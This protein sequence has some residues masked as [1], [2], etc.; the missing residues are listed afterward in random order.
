MRDNGPITNREIELA[1][2]ELLVSRTDTT[3]RITFVNKA[4]VDVCGYSEA[5][6]VGAPHNLVRH[7]H[8]PEAAF[9]DL[10]AT[11]KAGRPWEGLVKNRAKSGDFYWV[12]ANV[13]PVVEDGRVTG[14]IS[15]RSKPARDQVA[16]AERLYARMREGMLVQSGW[17]TK[18][19]ALRDSVSGRLGAVFALLFLITALVGWLGLDGM[20][21]SNAALRTVYEKR[22]VTAGQLGDVIDRMH[23]TMQQLTLLLVDVR[24]GTGRTVVDGR[25]QRIQGN[26][27]RITEVLDTYLGS[28]L[29]AEEQALARRFAELRGDFVREGLEPALAMVASGDALALERHHGTRLA[30]L[31]EAAHTANRALMTLQV[32]EAS[33][34]YATAR[35]EYDARVLQALAAMTVGA[36]AAALL[37]MLLLRTVR[38]PLARF[39]VHFD[40]IARGDVF[41]EIETP[42]TAEFQRVS[43]LLRALKAKVAYAEQERVERDR[44]AA[45]DRRTALEGMAA[46]V[47][48]EA[49]RAVEEVAARTGGMARD[50]EG[51]SDSAERV[52]VNAQTVAAAADQALSNAQTVAAASEELAASI[53]E[54]SSQVAHSSAVTR[55]AVESGQHTQQTIRSLSDAVGRI[56]EVVNLIQDV[57]GQTN[58]LALN[59]TIEAARAGEAGKGF[60]VVAQEVKNLA[61]QTAR[62]TEEITR[63]IAE[64]QAVTG[65]AV[66]AVEEI[67]AT[68]G[69]IDSIAGSIAAAMEEQAAAT[70][71]I[72]R[73][74]IE[75]S[76][77]A[78]E[79]SARIATVSQDADRTG[80]Q[81]GQV[82]I[83]ASEV[84]RSIEDLRRVLVRVVRTSTGDADR[85]R[86]PRF[87]VDEPCSVTVAGRRQDGRVTNLSL[88]GAMITG[89]TGM[90]EGTRGAARLDRFGVEVPFDVRSVEGPVVHV[91]FIEGDASAP[92]F[93]SL[94]ERLTQ[95]LR[96]IDA[97][98]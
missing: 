44:H 87:Q 11:I 41:H 17:S 54:I 59:A 77:A 26:V 42:A 33:A 60:A 92:A 84:A 91:R 88:G 13:T 50:A 7:P 95:G 61:N 98:A 82:R 74:V 69:E 22:T 19:A 39:E 21:G 81:A 93:R 16:E 27:A 35:G 70:Q 51:M 71:E 20:A 72:S 43:G 48:R 90:A 10:W 3:G 85:R 58:L 24:D 79:V 73:N 63:Q 46:T 94:F 15:I 14:Y 55:R 64:I 49:G 53:R 97:A 5:E 1:D 36:A 68:I 40:A 9:A 38:R 37:G 78:Q 45:E 86:L 52:S 18:L 56:G 8:M 57:A 4:F 29:D 34:A 31:F 30:P 80:E 47:E 12:R 23:D 67:G 96:P 28:G 66:S 25:V 62:S 2:G 65:Q 76:A 89:L 6:L 75:T 32:R 83:G